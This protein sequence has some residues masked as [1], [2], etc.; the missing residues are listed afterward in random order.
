MRNIRLNTA[1]LIIV[2]CA[3]VLAGFANI[4]VAIPALNG[5]SVHSELG[6]EQFIAALS[7][8]TPS[9]S[10]R[11]ILLA[12]EDKLIEVRIL[13]D[14]LSARTFKRIW[15][16]GMAINSSSSELKQNAQNMASFSN[17]IRLKLIQGDIFAIDRSDGEVRILLNGSVLGTIADPQFFDLLLRTWIGPVP[18]SSDFRSGLL[19]GG[20]VDSNL[21]A[22]FRALTPSNDR[23]EIVKNAV[24]SL[25]TTSTAAVAAAVVGAAPNPIKPEIVL[26]KP[27]IGAPDMAVTTPNTPEVSSATATPTP[28][29]AATTPTPAVTTAA[30]TVADTT[31][32]KVEAPKLA[33]PTPKPA[34]SQTTTA[35]LDADLLDEDEELDFTAESLLSQQLYIAELKKWSHR[36]LEYPP[37]ALSKLW[38]GNVRMSVTIDRSGNVI[39]SIVAEEAKFETLTR[40]AR[41]A[42]KKA[43]PFPAMPD[44]IAGKSFTFSLPIVFKLKN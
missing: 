32:P 11:D 22:Q 3:S 23:I 42:V 21:L 44:D 33:A 10:A 4:A 36:Y 17:L 26:N 30:Q 31:K 28:V 15:I 18:L 14:R 41:R 6:K 16:E 12:D 20:N 8:A 38:Q 39:E 7:V 34:K 5:L 19:V 29:P 40:A 1:K 35:L 13:A 24:A 25:A 37:R 27:V 2:A 43:S 9:E